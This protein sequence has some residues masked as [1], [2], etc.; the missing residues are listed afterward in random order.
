M[1]SGKVQIDKEID[2]YYED[3]GK[4]DALI[5]IPGLTC[6]TEFFRNNLNILAADKRII[7]YDP[8]SQGKS[9]ITE[10]GN[11]F[12]QRGRDLAAFIDA[13]ELDNVVIAGWSLGAYDAYAYFEQFGL[14]KVRAFVNIDM[15]PKVIQINVDD[16]SEGSLEEVHGMYSSVLATDQPHFFEGYAHYMII[17]DAT[18]DEVEWIVGQ[19]MHTPLVIAAQIV[20]DASFCDYSE[21]V[22]NIAG[23]I[24]VMHFIKQD[25]AETAIKWLDKNT[26]G[27]AKEVMGGHMMFWEEPEVFNSKFREFLNT[28]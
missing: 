24:P 2:I 8:R 6:T 22:C 19:S 12:A 1:Q 25:W 16:W 3:H 7:A 10:I 20:A 17:R 27:I 11:N 18:D 5:F 4:G 13:L 26:P 23:E 14:D 21:V 9:T 15:P 28:L